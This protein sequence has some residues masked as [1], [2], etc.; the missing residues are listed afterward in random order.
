MALGLA[1]GL[2]LGLVL[3]FALPA[4]AWTP[5]MQRR[6]AT[7]AARLGPSDLFRQ[8]DKHRLEYEKGA[9]APFSDRDPARHGKNAD[10]SGT[11]D[12]AISEE[13][14]AAIAAIRSHRPFAEII[15]RL[16][17]VSHYVADANNPLAASNQDAEEG[18]Y[19]ADFLIY[20]ESAEPRLPLVFYGLPRGWER[21]PDLSSLVRD[22]L[23]RSR[24][25]YPAVGREYRRIG[26]GSGRERFDDRSSA[27]AVASLAF[28]HAVTDAA[29]ALR[30]IWLQAG[31]GDA[32]RL[33]T[34]GDGILSVPKS[35]EPTERR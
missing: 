19:F 9:L 29:I 26:F 11:L 28:S 12:R 16:G 31:G 1:L 5:E 10:G 7:E 32:R 33:P 25:F 8:I 14:A 21:R 34:E 24:R 27:F 17:R 3:G 6:I 2:V 30:K 4:G 35:R 13:S 18:R 22:A 20:A 23:A 15:G